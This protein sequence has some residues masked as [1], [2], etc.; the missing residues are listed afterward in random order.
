[1]SSELGNSLRMLVGQ[2]DVAERLQHDPVGFVHRYRSQEDVEVAAFFA[3]QLAF[4]RVASFSAPLRQI[5]D[6]ADSVGGPRRWIECFDANQPG[7]LGSLQYRWIRPDDFV[8]VTAALRD[9]LSGGRL[10]ASHFVGEDAQSVLTTGIAALHAAC[11]DQG[12][13]PLTRGQKAFLASPVAGSACKRWC[14]F[15]RWMVREADGIDFGVWTH[16]PPS[17]LIIPVDTHVHRIAQLVGLTDRRTANWRTAVAITDALKA[18]D[19]ADPVRFDFALAHLGI[20]GACRSAFDAEICPNC[21]LLKLCR[22]A[23]Q[24]RAREPDGPRTEVRK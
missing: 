10:L 12:G 15:L 9:L 1:M 20:S 19:S 7:V 23:R 13:G 22:V 6:E 2:V 8:V 21:A 17:Q 14:M 16:L 18:F 24:A 5:L 4:G 3:S 11:Q